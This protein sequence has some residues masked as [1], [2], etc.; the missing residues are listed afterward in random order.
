MLKTL[1]ALGAILTLGV[2]T[3]SATALNITDIDGSWVNAFPSGN[4]SAISNVAGSGTD[5][6][7]WGGTQDD[8]TSGSGYDFVPSLDLAPVT[9][10]AAFSLGEFTHVNNAVFSTIDSIDYTF[11]FSTNGVPTILAD[12]FHFNHNETENLTGTSPADD[13]IVTLSSINLNQSITVGADTYFFNLLGFSNNDGATFGNVFRSPEG[14][15]NNIR[16]YGIVTAQPLNTDPVPEP[17]SLLLL[18]PAV[19]F[20]VARRRAQRK[21]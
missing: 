1:I 6:V 13:D 17:A 8:L 18:A 10:G 7:R 20:L 11:Q 2:G 9:L 14:H 5:S 19:A 12:L 21:A 4:V 16:L 15:R 3:A